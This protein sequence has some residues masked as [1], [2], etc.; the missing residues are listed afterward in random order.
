MSLIG[1][2]PDKEQVKSMLKMAGVTCEMIK[3]IDAKRF[4]SNVVVE[5]YNV[6]RQLMA[7][8]AL[9][10]GFKTKGE[11]AHIQLI[12]Y[13]NDNYKEITEY[14]IGLINEL[15]TTR[16]RIEYDGFFVQE[17]YVKR[18]AG[19]IILVISKLESIAK[20]KI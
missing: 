1:I 19:D 6:I 7:A 20:G 4:P 17:D 8:I 14:E 11:G 16:N 13:L 12:E 2:T 9:L 10:D 18:K 5:Y 15:R 3:G